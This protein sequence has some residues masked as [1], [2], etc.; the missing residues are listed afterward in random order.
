MT[1]SLSEEALFTLLTY[2]QN[3]ISTYTQFYTFTCNSK[4]KKRRKN[5]KDDSLY[6]RKLNILL[7]CTSQNVA[8]YLHDI[9]SVTRQ[10]LCIFNVTPKEQLHE[11]G[12]HAGQ[13]YNNFACLSFHF[14]FTTSKVFL[15]FVFSLSLFCF[16]IDYVCRKK[17]MRNDVR[18]TK[19][20]AYPIAIIHTYIYIFIR[21]YTC[22]SLV[23]LFLDITNL[24]LF[25]FLLMLYLHLR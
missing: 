14:I 12:T 9:L 17:V 4:K 20:F 24:F 11:E 13:K 18:L 22:L 3:F 21:L 15:P 7:N 5:K 2:F 19:H 25:S 8:V 23:V 10:R 16:H 6:D 1:F